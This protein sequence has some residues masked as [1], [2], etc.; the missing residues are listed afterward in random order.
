MLVIDRMNADFGNSTFMAM[1]NGYY[2]EF[3]TNVVEISKEKAEGFFVAPIDEKEFL[4]NILLSTKIGEEEKYYLVGEAAKRQILGNSHI[5]LH[6]KTES[7]IPIATFLAAVA[8]YYHLNQDKDEGSENKVKIKYF[9]TML[10]IWL[11]VKLNKFSEMQEKMA[12]RFLGTHVVNI[13]TLGLERTL[14]I[15]VEES[16]CRIEGEVARWALKKTFSLEDNSEAD[17]FKNHDTVIVD[18]GGGTIDMSLLPAGL[19]APKSRESMA[20]IAEIPYLA[21]IEKLQQR[22][23]EHFDNVRELEEF[24]VK[25]IG[26]TKMERKDGISGK[27]V[28]LKEPIMRSL[29]EYVSLLI[30]KIEMAFPAPKDKEYKYCYIGGVA[31][32]LQ[33][34]IERYIEKE[35]GQEIFNSNHIFPPNGRKLNLYGLE[36]ISI[37]ETRQKQTTAK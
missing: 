12:K 34:S 33:E 25:N 22:L 31:S 23:I 10:P 21:H 9:S 16:K 3:A 7:D 15:E 27:K 26:K 14:E 30:P 11:L 35:Y 20:F 36:I 5:K 13:H 24:I 37:A 18:I 17:Q 28:D 32:V 6:N 8:Y 1:I 19:E 4:N 2:V 29:D